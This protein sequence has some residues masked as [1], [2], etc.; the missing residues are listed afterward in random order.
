MGYLEEIKARGRD[1]NPFMK[2]MGIE[3]ESFGGGHCQLSTTVGPSMLNGQGWLQGG[4]YVALCDEAM[5]LALYTAI[6][7]GEL[8]ATIS[9]STDYLRGVRAGRV[10]AT[11]LVRRSGRRVAFTEG[12]LHEGSADGP[13][14]SQTRASFL[15]IRQKDL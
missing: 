15:I 5:A 8:I 3:V 1:A 9:E 7:E 11:G 14:L 6:K 12:C 13:L 2:H 4:L 10:V